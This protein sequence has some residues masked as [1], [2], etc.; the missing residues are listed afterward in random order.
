MAALRLE[1]GQLRR[2]LRGHQAVHL[3]VAADVGW[4]MRVKVTAS[5]GAGSAWAQSAPTA[6]V[7]TSSSTGSSI[8]WGGGHREGRTLTATTYGGTWGVP[9]PGTNDME[10]VRV[11]RR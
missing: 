4:T 3:V 1:R 7:A 10:P 9:R 6:L 11:E 8:Y 5:N 2:H